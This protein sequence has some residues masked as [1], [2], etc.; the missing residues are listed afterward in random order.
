M[1][2]LLKLAF[3]D[4]LPASVK[5]FSRRIHGLS[6]RVWTIHPTI[7]TADNGYLWQRPVSM[8]SE[9]R[10]HGSH[11]VIWASRFLDSDLADRYMVNRS[12]VARS[13]SKVTFV[14]QSVFLVAALP[15][16]AVSRLRRI[17][18]APAH[19]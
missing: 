11:L 1:V 18:H 12:F 5:Y 13:V 6:N 8:F 10:K 17:V 7:K 4:P 19:V 3:E 9:F 16:C 2:W 15:Q 14:A